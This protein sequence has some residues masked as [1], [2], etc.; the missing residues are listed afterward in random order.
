[1]S[2]KVQEFIE[3]WKE[4]RSIKALMSSEVTASEPE[5][6]RSELTKLGPEEQKEAQKALEDVSSMLIKRIK[7]LKEKREKLHEEIK[8]SKQTKKACLAYQKQGQLSPTHQEE[9][10]EN[11]QH[12]I[13]KIQEQEERLRKNLKTDSKTDKKSLGK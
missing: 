9:K 12:K 1:M 5:D 7:K 4:K 2:N 8:R 3:L 11:T 10:A 6:L 13:E